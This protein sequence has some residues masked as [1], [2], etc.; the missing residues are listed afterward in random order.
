MSWELGGDG[1]LEVRVA[2]NWGEPLS[3]DEG[4][5]Q[6]AS[7]VLA[8]ESPGTRGTGV[9]D[10]SVVWVPLRRGAHCTGQSRPERGKSMKLTPVRSLVSRNRV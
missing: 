5:A 7:S 2:E 9:W 4:A 10:S 1:A 3:E 8:W 6:N